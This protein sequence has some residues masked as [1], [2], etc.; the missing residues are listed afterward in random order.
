MKNS[1]TIQ[2]LNK[3]IKWMQEEINSP[4]TPPTRVKNH[5]TEIKRLEIAIAENTENNI[6]IAVSNLALLQEATVRIKNNWSEQK[7]IALVQ[8]MSNNQI[9]ATQILSKL[10]N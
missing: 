1:N 9:E 3:R 2:K 5:K 7:V 8:Q 10:Y 4:F 6:S